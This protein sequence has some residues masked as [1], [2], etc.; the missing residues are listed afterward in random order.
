M[1]KN[2]SMICQACGEKN[3]PAFTSCWKCKG[4]LENPIPLCNPMIYGMWKKNLSY[5]AKEKLSYHGLGKLAYLGKLE[6]FLIISKEDVEEVINLFIEDKIDPQDFTS[7]LES[8]LTGGM[9][10]P[11]LS[12]LEKM[13]KRKP[14]ESVSIFNYSA[15]TFKCAIDSV[16]GGPSLWFLAAYPDVVAWIY[17]EYGTGF[18]GSPTSIGWIKMLSEGE[19][20]D[21]DASRDESTSTKERSLPRRCKKLV[22]SYKTKTGKTLE[23]TV[24]NAMNNVYAVTEMCESIGFESN[25]TMIAGFVTKYYLELSRNHRDR[26]TDEISLLAAA[27]ILDA[28]IYISLGQIN[29]IEIFNLAKALKG[30]RESLIEFIID[31]EVLLFKIDIPNMTSDEI[32][33]S[34]EEQ[35]GRIE[36]TIREIKEKYVSEPSFVGNIINFMLSDQ[37]KSVREMVGIKPQSNQSESIGVKSQSNNAGTIVKWYWPAMTSFAN[38]ERATRWAF[39]T[40]MVLTAIQTAGSLLPQTG[41][42]AGG[43]ADVFTILALGY[44]VKRKSRVCALVLCSYFLIVKTIDVVIEL[45]NNH[46]IGSLGGLAIACLTGLLFLNGVRGTFAYHKFNET[47]INRKIII[48]KTISAFIYGVVIWLLSMA[49]LK[50]IQS[51]PSEDAFALA[52]IPAD[53]IIWVSYLGWLPFTKGSVMMPNPKSVH[54]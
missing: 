28:Q 30:G 45:V 21:S 15:S 6:N 40:A 39:W 29:A 42:G 19:M 38:A 36:K 54:S 37:F 20:R 35:R 24:K 52:S 7:N 50:L 32:R 14:T 41:M 18:D 49:V 9:S 5:L 48:S 16:F 34:C 53:I 12:I 11:S 22:Q 25:F 3:N 46:K 1:G 2:N 51:H 8:L 10:N 43:F 17:E 31:L 26:F 33:N 23:T 4:R 13:E 27:G 44:G 47:I